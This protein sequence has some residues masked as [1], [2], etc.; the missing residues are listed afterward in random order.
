MSTPQT[1]LR[2]SI[3]DI[4][5]DYERGDKAELETLMRAWQG[6][7][8]PA[9]RRP[10]VV[11]HAR[12]IP[13][14]A[15]P[16]AGHLRLGGLVGRL[17]S[18]R[19]RAVPDL[20]PRLPPPAG[21]GPAKHRRLLVCDPA[22]LGRVQQLLAGERHP[23]GADRRDLRARRGA[24]RQPV[25]V[26]RAADGHRRPGRPGQPAQPDPNAP[27]YSKPA[28]YETVRYPLSGLVGTPA[29]QKTSAEHNAGFPNYA[30][31]VKTLDANIMAWLTLPVVS[32]E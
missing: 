14:R 9:P 17:L 29:D 15:V 7:Q 19:H 30:A 31:N 13:R 25:A 27:N 21:T 16:R 10:P 11:L 2:R 28:G 26:L 23:V 5:A 32:A 22:V 8:G 12:G 20:A 18:A 4:Q 3:A 1:R 6:H 24:D